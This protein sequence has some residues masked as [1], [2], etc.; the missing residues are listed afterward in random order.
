MKPDLSSADADL[1]R[2]MAKDLRQAPPHSPRAKLGGYVIAA[3][4][5]D[6]C[7]ASLLDLNGEYHYHPCSLA[8]HLWEFTGIDHEKFRAFVATGAGDE[9]VAAWLQSHSRVQEPGEIIAWNNR[10]RDKRV[11]ELSA[12]AQAYLEDYIPQVVS[13]PAQVKVFFDVFDAEE[14]R[15]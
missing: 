2:P 13:N 4:S 5:L 6:K 3:R 8:A 1:L 9:Q 15:L 7:R 14:G 11:S 10:M 12:E